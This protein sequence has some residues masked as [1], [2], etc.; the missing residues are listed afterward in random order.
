MVSLV[1]NAAEEE[2]KPGELAIKQCLSEAICSSHRTSQDN[3]MH[4]DYFLSPR[5]GWRLL[6]SAVLESVLHL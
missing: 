1:W 6:D 2:R 3:W 4:C 5:I